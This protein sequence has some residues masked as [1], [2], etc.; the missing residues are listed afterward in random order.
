[1]KQRYPCTWFRSSAS[2][3]RAI[4]KVIAHIRNNAACGLHLGAGSQKIPGLINC[5]LYDSHADRKIDARILEGIENASVDLIESHHMIE[6]L[7][8][9]D[10]ATALAEWARVLKPGG[11]L[12]LT[13]P[14]LGMVASRWRRLAIWHRVRACKY[15]R[16]YALKMLFGSQEHEGMFHRSGYDR[17]YLSE[18]LA[19]HGLIV[20]F[21]YSPYPRRLTPSL[22]VIA[23]KK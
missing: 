3:H 23:R 10:A 12:V 16:D 6:H 11:Y 20:E 17:S 13:C 8:F 7:S 22:L 15:E 21:S 2:V 19:S 5:D 1:M 9:A 4:D 14:D 18:M